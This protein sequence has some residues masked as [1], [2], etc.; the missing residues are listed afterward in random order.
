MYRFKI[1]NRFPGGKEAVTYSE[2]ATACGLSEPTL[3][4]IVRDLMTHRIF[5]QTPD[6][7]IA[8]TSAS[9]LF[10]DSHA[11]RQ[12]VGMVLEEMWPAATKV[13][14]KLSRGKIAKGIQGIDLLVSR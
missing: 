1:A 3:R 4:R 13:T 14:L 12:W 7:K 10:A 6:G 2:L 11:I 8:H 9:K 5:R